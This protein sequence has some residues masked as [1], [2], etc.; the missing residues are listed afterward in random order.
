[1]DSPQIDVRFQAEGPEDRHLG[2]KVDR[3]DTEMGKMDSVKERVNVPVLL[4][5]NKRETWK[6]SWGHTEGAAISG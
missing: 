6:V 5:G 3:K 4:C 2:Q 1:M